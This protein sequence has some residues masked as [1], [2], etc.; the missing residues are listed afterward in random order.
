[1]VDL[2]S[3]VQ[4]EGPQALLGAAGMQVPAALAQV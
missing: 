3:G 1:M 2:L 4:L